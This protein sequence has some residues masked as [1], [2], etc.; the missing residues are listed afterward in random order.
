MEIP[1]IL[2]D[3]IRQGQVV[4]FLGS[5]ASLGAKHPEKKTPPIGNQLATLICDKYLGDE[6]KHLPLTQVSELAISESSLFDVQSFVADIFKDFEPS[7]FHE[8]IPKFNWAAIITTNYDLIIEKAF[9]NVSRSL[10]KLVVFK[11]DTDRIEEKIKKQNQVMY[12]KLHGCITDINDPML[13][14]ILTPEQYITHKENR[15]QLFNRL[16]T[17]SINYPFLFIG[18]S[19]SDSDLRAIMLELDKLKDAKPRSYL[20]TPIITE[21]EKRFWSNKKMAHIQMSFEEFI[22]ALN[23]EIPDEI[24]KLSVLIEKSDHPIIKK[25]G[26]KENIKFSDSL[27]TL[28]ARDVEY[29]NHSI[30]VSQ[31]DPKTFYKGYFNSFA[32]ILLELDVKRNINDKI[33][34]EVF[35]VTEELR[36]EI[37]EFNI[38]LG[39]AGAGKSVSL[40]R[41]AYDAS[42]VFDKLCLFAKNNAF[43]NYDALYELYQH[44]NERIFLFIDP[45]TDSYECLQEILLRAKRDKLPLTVIGGERKNE[46]NTNCEELKAFV[47]HTYEM[48]Y[49]SEKE[50]EILIN[51]LSIHKSLGHLEG[52]SFEKQKSELSQKAGRQ[53]LVA[54]HEATL[55]KPFSDIILDEYRS[56][57]SP[58]A[59]SL[60]LTI[61]ILH[62]L[63]IH[64]RAGLIS[65]AH[66][67][68]FSEFQNK[69]FNPLEYI[70][71]TT[72]DDAT[73]DYYYQS[74]HS[75]IAEIVF[76][77]VLISPQDRYDE[78]MRIIK[79]LD[80][81]YN[82][83]SESFRSLMK[84]KQLISLFPDPDMIRQLYD[85]AHSIKANDPM[86]LQQEA[87]F[88]M[89][90]KGGNIT[91]AE[92]LL[93]KAYDIAP[94]NSA[95]A[96]SM[97]VLDYQKSKKARN[98]LEKNKYRED[99]K[100]IA[101]DLITSNATTSHP[102]H[103][104]VSI[105]LDELEEIL[106]EGDQASIE[107]KLKE[108]E[109]LI[110]TS[111]QKFPDESFL[112]DAEAKYASLL[113]QNP[114]ALNSLQKAFE[115]N[116]RS[117]Y[118]ASRL[119]QF[120][121]NEG[122]EL[123]AMSVLKECIDANPSDKNANYKL[124]IMLLKYDKDNLPEIKFHLRRSFT[125]GDSNYIA[126]FWYGRTIYLM[127]EFDDANKIFKTLSN[128]NLD[129]RIKKTLRAI[130]KDG[131]SDK[132]FSGVIIHLESSYGFIIRDGTQDSIY[133]YHGFSDTDNW[134]N[135]KTND[136]VTFSLGFNYH[137]P[138]AINILKL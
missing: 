126:Q 58:K 134:D 38:I 30:K 1:K 54:L 32:P 98:N 120:Y 106:N 35:L 28:L 52:L 109:K 19:L 100:K 25:Y 31:L 29:V 63:G 33:L 116:K 85:F 48:K 111:I 76:E 44:T 135:L 49:L 34:S 128:L 107:R 102:Y 92:K 95:L 96:H 36:R 27:E 56:I 117:S 74:R 13:P 8:L 53:L 129:S 21:A 127:N 130:I 132:I 87:I 82:S 39:H 122:N 79:S 110:N 84:G 105:S 59:Q 114:K 81:G 40:K 17:L 121:E 51:L 78:Y 138:I 20:I 113:K 14:L 65:R 15:T 86:L 93:E 88:E 101:L 90:C 136:R 18:H 62:R 91:R 26:N 77:R 97:S 118:L 99:S 80:L 55:G 67:I 6:Y 37:V 10:Q 103:T 57:P 45:I 3:Q 69:F 43:V 123:K 108:L 115:T 71:F 41:L 125:E 24:R 68:S 2:I 83:D 72:Q 104:I 94:H 137:G 46:W 73:K 61:C 42:V 119:A 22:K 75:H 124:S 16:S 4:L 5:G 50:I 47:N 9:Q 12:I 131:E 66:N 60:Y 11:K 7:P 70:V 133:C 89:N 112:L 23:N 64:V